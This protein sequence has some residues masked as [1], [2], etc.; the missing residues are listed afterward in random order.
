MKKIKKNIFG[1]GLGLAI[2][3]GVGLSFAPISVFAEGGGGNG[4]TGNQIPC[5][6]ASIAS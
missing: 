3:L 2:I 1:I 5:Y 4:C 6:S